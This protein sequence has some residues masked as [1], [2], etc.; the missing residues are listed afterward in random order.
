MVI[1]AV[2]F[3]CSKGKFSRRL[4]IALLCAYIFLVVSSTVLTRQESQEWRYNIQLFWTYFELSKGTWRAYR[5][6]EQLLLN[7]FMFIPVGFLFALLFVKAGFF[8]TL[9]TCLGISF[10]IEMLQ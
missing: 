4:S 10:F 5:L 2:V 1:G 3:I 8:S 9:L 6:L 7:I